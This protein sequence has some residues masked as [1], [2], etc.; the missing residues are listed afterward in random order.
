MIA[1]AIN[2]FSA[3]GQ[4]FLVITLELVL[5]F[6][7]VSFLVGLIREY[8]P[9]ERIRRAL[10]S[11]HRVTGT[12]IGAFFGAL[13]PF[14]SCSTI[15]VLAGLLNSRVPF[16]ACIAFLLASPLLNPVIVFM[17]LAFFGPI[18]TL[19]YGTVTFGIA[20]ASG[21]ILED[22]NFIRFVKPL[23]LGKTLLPQGTGSGCCA[24]NPVLPESGRA[25]C[26]P[27]AA[28]TATQAA[29][30]G[31]SCSAAGAPADTWAGA[32][33]ARRM[34]SALG[35]SLRIF[36]QVLPYLLL[37][38]AAGAFIYGFVPEDL[39]VSL[40]GPENPLAIPAA[41]VIGIPMYIRAETIIPVSAVLLAKGMGL[42]AV[43]AL[44]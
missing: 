3:A 35:F 41:A 32:T 19:L 24:G 5:L 31:C 1:G 25:G 12:A 18:P 8:L 38:A 16:G 39:I 20:V 4:F 14:C 34:R 9:E 2:D 37:G 21:I 42:G 36:R 6:V 26:C 22:R 29:G 40:A 15:P 28:G 17:V 30:C 10:S 23:G 27:G 44:I 43:M 13:T 7:G 11:R 33:H